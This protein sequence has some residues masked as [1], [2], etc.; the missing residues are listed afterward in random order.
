[1]T[2]DFA[3]D[4]RATSSFVTDPLYASFE[5]GS[6]FPHTYTNANGDSINAGWDG[7]PGTFDV[8]NTNDPRIAG[9]SFNSTPVTFT[10]DLSSGSAPGAGDYAIDLASPTRIARTNFAVKDNATT[11]IAQS[12]VAMAANHYIDATL[13]DVTATTTWTGTPVV[14]TFATTT[15]LF[16]LNPAA[17]D[18]PGLAHFRLTLQGGASASAPRMFMLLGV[19]V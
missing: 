19:G 2:F 12:D 7:A 13:A 5:G 8:A 10:V 4:Y 17:I 18:F 11:L 6:V 3:W 16:V 9:M 1:M 14:K 15:C